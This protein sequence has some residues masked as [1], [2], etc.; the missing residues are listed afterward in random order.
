MVMHSEGSIAMVQMPSAFN[1]NGFKKSE[2]LSG[3]L[4]LLAERRKVDFS[5]FRPFV[6]SRE[7]SH[8]M[9]LCRC[10]K[11]D[12]YRSLLEKDS[13]EIDNLL[14]SLTI[15]V[16]EFFRD[17]LVFTIL[18]KIAI[19]SMLENKASKKDYLIRVWSAGC[20]SGEEAYSIAILIAEALRKRTEPFRFLVFGT[21]IEEKDLNLA[22]EG[23]YPPERLGMVPL[24]FLSRYFHGKNGSY[25]VDEGLRGTTRFSRHNLLSMEPATPAESVYGAFDIILCCNVLVYMTPKIQEEVFERLDRALKPGGFLVLGE[26]EE[27][28]AQHAAWYDTVCRHCRVYR[29]I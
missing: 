22:R 24:C 8:R 6:V 16:S 29:K 17:P 28:P 23:R 26:A 19:P 27:V 25:R 10:Q 20:S 12:E 18:S 11:I 1:G 4:D 14:D 7:I 2:A 13:D 9:E 5:G 15:G 3:I 21:D